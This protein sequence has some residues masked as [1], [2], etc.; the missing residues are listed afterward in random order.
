[1]RFW[2]SVLVVL[3]VLSL[4]PSRAGADGPLRFKS[5]ATCTT[6]KGSVIDLSPGRYLP[7]PVWVEL[8]TTYT[9][10]ENRL[11]RLEAENKS[12]RQSASGVGW[13][14]SVVGIVA[15]GLASK[16]LLGD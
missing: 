13:G 1:M 11:T 10:M 2:L 12:L 9:V 7:E 5:A 3:A 16:Y 15:G 6:E 8:D 4:A 14:W